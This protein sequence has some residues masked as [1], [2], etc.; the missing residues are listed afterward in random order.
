MVQREPD[1]KLRIPA[2]EALL[3]SGFMVSRTYT[4]GLSAIVS[5]DHPLYPR[6]KHY[7][8]DYERRLQEASLGVD[9]RLPR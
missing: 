4:E 6:F 3:E 2:S 8:E 7:R 9:G 5:D 1:G